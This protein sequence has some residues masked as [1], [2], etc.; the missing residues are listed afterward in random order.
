MKDDGTTPLDSLEFLE[1]EK[2][3]STESCQKEETSASG[4]NQ[5][6]R[7]NTSKNIETNESSPELESGLNLNNEAFLTL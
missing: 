5:E 4:A 3:N 6:E 7:G 2:K 1:N